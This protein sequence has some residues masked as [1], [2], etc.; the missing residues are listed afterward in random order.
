MFGD[1]KDK[2]TTIADID[3]L[4]AMMEEDLNYT[5]MVAAVK[6]A[7]LLQAELMSVDE[8]GAEIRRLY[9]L[10]VQRRATAIV[11]AIHVV[12]ELPPSPIAVAESIEVEV[13]ERL[14]AQPD[15]RPAGTAERKPRPP[16][17][18]YTWPSPLPRLMVLALRR[19]DDKR[20]PHD[21]ALALLAERFRC[22]VDEFLTKSRQEVAEVLFPFQYNY[23]KGW[24]APT[25]LYKLLYG[26]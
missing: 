21:R 9:P 20:I 10:L 4:I 3:Q 25:G 1:L 2:M 13:A 12:P 8:L 6:A 17:N 11:E 22:S 23:G 16:Y 26:H 18:H 24:R 14:L 15:R 7:S 5:K 19:T